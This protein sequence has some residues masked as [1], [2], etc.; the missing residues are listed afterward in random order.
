MKSSPT[1]FFDFRLLAACALCCLCAP[2]SGVT[3]DW[4]TVGNAG[5]SGQL[6]GDPF[7]FWG[8]ATVGAVNYE[9]RIGKYEVT[10]AQYVEFLNGV[11]QNGAN[12]L[13]LYSD[14]MGYDARGGINFNSGNGLGAKYE[15]KSGQANNPVV[16]IDWYDAVRFTNWVENGGSGNANTEDGAYTLLGGT[17]VPSNAGAITRN[18][19][20]NI[21]LPTEDEWY[22]AAYHKNDGATGNYW[23]YATRTDV[24]PYSDNPLSINTPD[25]SNTGNVYGGDTNNGLGYNFGFAV[26]GTDLPPDFTNTLTD[27]GA[28]GLAVGPYGTFDMG[29]NVKEWN[30]TLAI[31]NL[32]EIY[33]ALN[34]GSWVNGASAVDSSL[35]FFGPVVDQGNTYDNVGFRLAGFFADT[36]PGGGGDG[37]AAPEPSTLLLSVLGAIALL[38]RRRKSTLAA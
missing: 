10:N 29:D 21:F 4:V 35:R 14:A 24:V 2:A 16:F 19:G 30:E 7:T 37:G 26:T 5:N 13:G 22:K 36:G 12:A 15:V 11:D 6:A 18:S 3:I 38:R 1:R 17:A 32:G 20:A 27:V 9:Y 31:N 34:G 23:K 33:A 8:S 28:Y 25:A